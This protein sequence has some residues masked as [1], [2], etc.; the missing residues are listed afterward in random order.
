MRKMFK[1]KTPD[2]KRD[3]ESKIRHLLSPADPKGIAGALGKHLKQTFS[4]R[5]PLS[6][7]QQV[8]LSTSQPQSQRQVIDPHPLP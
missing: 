4:R 8:S 1:G 6:M 2:S 5:G 7:Q 3:L